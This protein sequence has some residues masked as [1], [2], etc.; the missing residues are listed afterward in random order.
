MAWN[1]R[2]RR[3][4]QCGNAACFMGHGGTSLCAL[5]KEFEDAVYAAAE[6]SLRREKYFRNTLKH[7][8]QRRGCKRGHKSRLQPEVAE[9]VHLEAAYEARFETG[10]G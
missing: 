1:Y 7:R 6:S 5:C 10:D 8:N 2:T 3:C 9:D 4:A